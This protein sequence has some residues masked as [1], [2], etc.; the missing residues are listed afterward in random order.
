MILIANIVIKLAL[1][2]VI[3]ASKAP[4]RKKKIIILLQH[5]KLIVSIN[6]DKMFKNAI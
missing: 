6:V 2:D 5:R 1:E 3:H 4:S